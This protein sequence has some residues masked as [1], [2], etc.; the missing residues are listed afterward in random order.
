MN[1]TSFKILS[2][3]CYGTLID[4]ETGLFTALAPLLTRAGVSREEALVAYAEQESAQ[5]AETPTLIYSEILTRVH[6]SL[7][8]LWSIRTTDD[9]DIAFGRSISNWPAFP[10]TV[11]ALAYLKRYFRLVILS[12]VDR[13]S[14]ADSNRRLG[15]TFDGIHTAEDIG[16]YKPDARNFHYLLDRV[17]EMGGTQETLLHVAQSLYH[18]HA[19][20]NTAGITTCWIDRRAGEPGGATKTTSD[21]PRYAWRFASLAELATAHRTALAGSVPRRMQG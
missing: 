6:R 10:D 5:E 2:F 11:P 13:R 12:N 3:D 21:T 4:W 1:L 9:E 16:S 15:V 20:A 14:F 18:D 8:R 17:A 19:P 7:G